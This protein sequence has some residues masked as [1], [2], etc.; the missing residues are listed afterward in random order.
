VL[1]LVERGL[2]GLDDDVTR[3]LR[4]VSLRRLA[5]AGD[6]PVTPR[7]L[8]SHTAG[9]STPGFPG[10]RVDEPMPSVPEVLR[11]MSSG[12]SSVNTGE[13]LVDLPP[14]TQ[15][16]YSGGGTTL[17]QQMVVDL[18]GHDWAELMRELVLV[19]FGMDDSAFDQPIAAERAPRA[20]TAHDGQGRPLAGGR[21]V[22][23]E[24]AAAGLWT[25]ASDLSSFLLG[26]QRILRGGSGPI[27]TEMARAMCTEVA[28]GPYGLGPEMAGTGASRRFGH[29]GTNAG[30]C[31]QFAG[32]IEHPSGLAV[33]T[34][35]DG[36]NT[37][38]GEIMRSIAD[39][40]GWDGFDAT[41]IDVVE[42]DP[43]TLDRYA[44]RYVGPFGRPMTVRHADGQLFSPAPYGRR[45]LYAIAPTVLLDEETGAHLEVHLLDGGEVERIAVTVGGQEIMSFQPAG[46]E[47]P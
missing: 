29:N 23:P 30:F 42:L 7:L 46:E 40:Y 9:T 15:T 8:M 25:T 36:G 34:N 4:S 47:Q 2:F 45:H 1:A 27:S 10:Y 6:A 43:A 41:P 17:L 22:Y 31:S 39:V 12:L 13:V 33:M 35:G 24:L 28:P 38:L 14:G 21:H 44:G 16:R 20:A 37:L 3:H 26:V 5:E 18:T 19:P 11:G 32:W